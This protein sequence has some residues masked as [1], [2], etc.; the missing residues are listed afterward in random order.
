MRHYFRR[1][2]YGSLLPG[3]REFGHIKGLRNQ[4]S[5]MTLSDVVLNKG[6]M[7]IAVVAL[8]LKDSPRVKGAVRYTQIMVDEFQDI[9]PVDMQFIAAIAK[10]HNADLTLVGDD[11][12]TIFEWRGATPAYILNP[13]RYF[14]SVNDG[15][16]FET[17]V[18][19]RNYRSPKNIVEMAQRL[20][21]HNKDRVATNVSAV[22]TVNADVKIIEDRGFDELAKMI[23]DDVCRSK[24]NFQKV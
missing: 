21:R 16:P 13:D 23:I 11:D 5:R 14:A 24:P 12:Q 1:N 15:G 4:P 7:P 6:V 19:E 20:I 3:S 8:A 2:G 18:L 22:Q 10:M 17:F 9:N